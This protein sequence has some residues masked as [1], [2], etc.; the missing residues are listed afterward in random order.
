MPSDVTGNFSAA[1]G[2]THV[3]CIL[4]IKF[5]RKG[6]EIVGVGVHFVA[7]PRLVGATVPS[8][9]MRDDSVALLAEEQ[10]LSVPSI[11]VERP[12]VTEHYGLALSP[13][14]VINLCAIFSV[15]SRHGFLSF[16]LFFLLK[17]P[18]QT[19]RPRQA[20]QGM[21]LV[22]IQVRLSEVIVLLTGENM[23][24]E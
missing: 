16:S 13:V 6:G 17:T 20:S 9:V 5:F 3:D 24:P 18:D 23:C 19:V 22:P 11:C 14:L 8:P 2:M 21:H 4:Q 15:D 12:P 7:V 10:H 1:S